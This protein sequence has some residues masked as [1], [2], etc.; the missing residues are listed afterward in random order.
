M[1]IQD[2][3]NCVILGSPTTDQASE[4]QLK[5]RG[6]LTPR[7]AG[8]LILALEQRPEAQPSAVPEHVRKASRSARSELLSAQGVDGAELA[9]KLECLNESV[10][11]AVVAGARRALTLPV[12]FLVGPN[13]LFSQQALQATG[14][15]PLAENLD[16]GL[17]IVRL[18]ELDVLELPVRHDAGQIGLA[19]DHDL[20]DVCIGLRDYAKAVLL[21]GDESGDEIGYRMACYLLKKS[22]RQHLRVEEDKFGNVALLNISLEALRSDILDG[23]M[24]KILLAGVNAP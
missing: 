14:L 11:Q 7:E 23:S 16:C 3:E 10:R 13:G 4:A 24:R 8:Y 6:A 22:G 15:A 12:P 20:I 5:A 18:A 9:G 1:C 21:D 2:F 19:R 17:V